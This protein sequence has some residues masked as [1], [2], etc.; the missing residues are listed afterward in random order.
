LK[1]TWRRNGQTFRSAFGASFTIKPNF[2]SKKKGT[3]AISHRGKEEDL[4]ENAREEGQT[5][6]GQGTMKGPSL[7][8][9]FA[10]KT[11]IIAICN[12]CRSK[13]CTKHR[14]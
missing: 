10:R 3:I 14:N 13:Q 1:Q 9:L 7:G 8:A 6:K 12:Q 5:K 11:I 2:F 4:V